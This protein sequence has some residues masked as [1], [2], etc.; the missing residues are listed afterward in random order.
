MSHRQPIG[1]DNP[2]NLALQNHSGSGNGQQP[3]HS[4][5]DNIFDDVNIDFAMEQ[6]GSMFYHMN[7]KDVANPYAAAKRRLYHS[8]QK[9][10]QSN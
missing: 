9:V 3:G 4:N 8:S 6:S 1:E 10:L 7:S 5:H 2:V